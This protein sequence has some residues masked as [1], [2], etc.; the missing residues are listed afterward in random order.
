MRVSVLLPFRSQKRKERTQGPLSP[1]SR[2][3]RLDQKDMLMPSDQLLAFAA[4]TSE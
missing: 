3:I 1:F 2:V 4:P